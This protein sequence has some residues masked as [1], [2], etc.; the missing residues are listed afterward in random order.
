M[1]QR[2]HNHNKKQLKE[3]QN[4][5]D[6]GRTETL[7]NSAKPEQKS[8]AKYLCNT[9][10]AELIQIANILPPKFDFD[11]KVEKGTYGFEIAFEKFK[12]MFFELSVVEQFNLVAVD[13]GKSY[14]SYSTSISK[15]IEKKNDFRFCLRALDNSQEIIKIRK[16]LKRN[17]ALFKVAQEKEIKDLINA[18]EDVFDGFNKLYS[19]IAPLYKFIAC[20]KLA[21]HLR[22]EFDLVS[23]KHRNG[24]M[25]Y[26]TARYILRGE[27]KDFGV[28]DA[29]A[30]AYIDEWKGLF[31]VKDW[32]SEYAE[33]LIIILDL[34]AKTAL[35]LETRIS[36]VDLIVARDGDV[37]IEIEKNAV[38][39]QGVNISRLR[40]C[41]YC[42]KLF[43]ANRK[44]A[45]TC[46]PKHARNRRMKLLREN[47]K[48][49]GQLYLEA[50][51]KKSK[52]KEN[53]ENGSL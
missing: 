14:I 32:N 29:E 25:F 23:A 34:L 2:A 45:Y 24:V 11:W 9:K 40:I 20:W 3:L 30:K 4:V 44:D 43:W 42:K 39:L 47:W 21:E 50:R 46:S 10:L 27:Y 1:Q 49:S 5:I 53:K 33:R 16:L 8:R 28:T 19:D 7:Q 41:E 36:E 12:R 18:D 26:L 17:I 37:R 22:E 38:A 35:D 48:K 13:F 15:E 31:I 51:K 6:E 52:K